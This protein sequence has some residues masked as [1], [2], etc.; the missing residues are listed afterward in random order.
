MQITVIGA[1]A[2]GG[3]VGAHLLRAGH[4]VL[5]CDVDADHV[6]AINERGLRVTGPVEELTVP[7]LPTP[8]VR[9]MSPPPQ[10]DRPNASTTAHAVVARCLL[11]IARLRSSR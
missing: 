9:M 8:L 3:T 11:S 4:D 2:I 7:A 10:A 5:L 6:A 1:G